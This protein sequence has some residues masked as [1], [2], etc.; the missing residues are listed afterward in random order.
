MSDISPCQCASGSLDGTLAPKLGQVRPLLGVAVGLRA[1]ATGAVP[2][3]GLVVEIA[4]YQPNSAA[5]SARSRL[6]WSLLGT[7]AP[8]SRPQIPCAHSRLALPVRRNLADKPCE[9]RAHKN[10]VYAWHPR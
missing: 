8:S 4:G 10:C 7:Y 6:S 9:R 5:S 2:G 1:G 3:D